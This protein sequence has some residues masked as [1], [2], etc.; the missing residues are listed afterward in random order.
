LRDDDPQKEWLAKA[1]VSYVL[2]NFAIYQ[3][4]KRNVQLTASVFGIPQAQMAKDAGLTTIK[5]GSGEIERVDLN[6]FVREHFKSVWL[7]KGLGMPSQVS[8]RFDPQVVHFYG[9]SQYPTP[10]FKG[11]AR[12]MQ[13]RVYHQ[14]GRTFGWSDHGENIEVCKEAAL[15]GATYIERHFS[16][17]FAPRQSAWDSDAASLRELRDFC[18]SVAWEGQPEH[19]DACAKYL[20]RW[21]G[22]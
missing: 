18:E 4:S 10:Y 14:P 22:Q 15:H 3:A 8:W 6:D 12:L 11:L 19:T 9:V 1:Q 5:I 13:A 17:P 7:S 21:S 2:L 20:T 16:M